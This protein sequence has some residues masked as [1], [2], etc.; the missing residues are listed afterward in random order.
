MIRYLVKPRDR[1]FVKGYGFL[2]FAKNMGKNIGKNMSKILG[3]KYT[4]KLL[5]H[6]KKSVTDA[7]KTISKRAV[8]KQ[9][10]QPVI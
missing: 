8:Q 2:S 5:D 1:I 9:Q 3:G 10:K 4:Q 7:F 6:T